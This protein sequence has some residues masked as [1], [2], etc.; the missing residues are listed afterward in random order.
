MSSDDAVTQHSVGKSNEYE[1]SDRGLFDFMKKEDESKVIATEF[2]EKVQ[3][4]EPEPKFED[5]KVVEEEEKVTKPSLLEK[6]HRSSSS[7]SSVSSCMYI[8]LY[9]IRSIQNNIAY[10]LL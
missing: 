1:S 9:G 5:C 7:S 4:S 3:V 6:L 10:N 8:N 2:E